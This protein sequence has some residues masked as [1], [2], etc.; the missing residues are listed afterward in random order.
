MSRVVKIS[1]QLTCF[2]PPTLTKPSNYTFPTYAYAFFDAASTPTCPSGWA[3][4]SRSPFGYT[5]VPSGF[6]DFEPTEPPLRAGGAA[7]HAHDVTITFGSAFPRNYFSDAM[8]GPPILNQGHFTVTDPSNDATFP[9]LPLLFCE[10]KFNRDVGLSPPGMLTFASDCDAIDVDAD[11]Y[12]WNQSSSAS[13]SF[14]L[15]STSVSGQIN[16][17][18][19]I[20]SGNPNVIPVNHTHNDVTVNID[21]QP[22]CEYLLLDTVAPNRQSPS[23]GLGIVASSIASSNRGV[24]PFVQMQLCSLDGL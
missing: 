16:D 20:I 23:C 19:P 21:S 6:T 12:V 3:L 22:Q 7:T 13:G 9:Y 2:L 15:S 10:N 11:N 24:L 5:L 4:N 17:G 14:I 8:N 1:Q 18:A